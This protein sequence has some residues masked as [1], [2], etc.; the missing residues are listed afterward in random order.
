VVAGRGDVG[1]PRSPGRRA[2]PRHLEQVEHRLGRLAEPVG[3]LLVHGGNVGLGVDGRDPR[4]RLQPEPLARHVVVRDV[5]VDRQL[6]PDLGLFR[7]AVA[8]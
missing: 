6:H 5:R 4:V 2:Q 3:Q 8:L 1:E 7:R